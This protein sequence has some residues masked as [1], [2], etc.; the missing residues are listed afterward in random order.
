MIEP[1]KYFDIRSDFWQQVFETAKPYDDYLAASPPDKARNW[2]DM[3][4]KVPALDEDQRGQVFGHDR[5][6]NV[7]AVSGVWCGDCVRQGPMLHNVAKVAR[8]DLRWID[9]D[10]NIELRDEVRIVGAMRVPMV[11]FLTEDHH[12]I[13]RFG[14]RL[15]TVYRRKLASEMG[16]ACAVPYAQT[17]QSEL[18]AEQQEWVDIFERMLIMARLSPPL[19]QRHGD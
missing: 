15:L 18:A 6:L 12:E 19:R 8:A 4:M 1:P 5:V 11:V 13:G 16:A 2:R 17:P 7:L 10:E 14:D 9:R 3:Q